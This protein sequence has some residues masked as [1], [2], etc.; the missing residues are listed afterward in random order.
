MKQTRRMSLVE[1][2]TN[3]AVGYGIAVVTQMAVFPLFGL[4]ATLAQNMMMGAIFTVVSIVRS[5]ALRRVFEEIRVR[6]I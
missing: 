3:V 4:H 6:R 5:Y 2:L 1:A